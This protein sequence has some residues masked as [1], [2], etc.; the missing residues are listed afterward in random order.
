MRITSNRIYDEKS[1]KNRLRIFFIKH[2]I[3]KKTETYIL[4]KHSRAIKQNKS[5]STLIVSH[6]ILKSRILFVFSGNMLYLNTY[7]VALYLKIT[8]LV[9]Y[10][11]K[12]L[13]YTNCVISIKIKIRLTL[14]RKNQ[15]LWTF[16]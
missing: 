7:R 2:K 13:Q 8:R 12:I 16:V 15:M 14:Q 3:Y 9:L 11:T 6:F 4:K 10:K 5:N 1:A